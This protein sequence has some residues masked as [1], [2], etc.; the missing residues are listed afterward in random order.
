MLMLFIY[1]KYFIRGEIIVTKVEYQVKLKK[2]LQ[3]MIGKEVI[4]E[5][6][7]IGTIIGIEDNMF[8]PV[9]S[10]KPISPALRGEERRIW[11]FFS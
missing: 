1:V 9:S 3:L 8:W 6:F 5:S 11:R 4:H 10:E 7:G 2:L